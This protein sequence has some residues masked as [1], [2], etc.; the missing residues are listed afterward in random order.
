M[1]KVVAVGRLDNRGA[2]AKG[3]GGNADGGGND[4][5]DGV[6][7]EEDDEDGPPISWVQDEVLCIIFSLL[8]AKTLMITVPQVCKF[9]RGMCQELSGVHLD[10]RWCDKRKFLL[11]FLQGG[12]CCRCR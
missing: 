12:G 7:A 10:F 4:S 8:D 1:V 11:K 2:A 3:G 5:K 9:W 6:R